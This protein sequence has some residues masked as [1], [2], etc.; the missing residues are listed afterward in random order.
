V[1]GDGEGRHDGSASA[2]AGDAGFDVGPGDDAPLDG[3]DNDAAIDAPPD[4]AHD[5]A[6]DVHDAAMYAPIGANGGTVDRLHF[7]VFGDIRP[8]LPDDLSPYPTGIVMQVMDG[9]THENAQF[10]IG[11]G[12]YMLE[13]FCSFCATNQINSLIMGESHFRHHIFH[14]MGNHEC[15][16]INEG[17]CPEENETVALRTYRSRLIPTYA[18]T[19]FAWTIRT[20]LGDA[21]FIATSP[22]AW[23]TDQ[24]T[25]L[26]NELAVQWRYVFVIAHEP[27]T[28]V[29]PGTS[30]I[31][32]QIAA[33]PG[34]VTMRLYG[35]RHRYEHVLPNA[36][37]TGNAGAPLDGVTNWYGFVLIDQRADGNLTVTSYEVG[38]PPTVFESFV[39]T[40]GGTITH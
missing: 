26:G 24:L 3:A 33:R 36:T 38:N 29:G 39:L 23:S 40:P 19:Y 20:S 9:I 14:A 15:L 22:N 16:T 1:P 30:D 11:T 4:V 34:G 32:N 6:H 37:I 2:E 35:H 17:N 27:P 10:A 18:H 25:W 8:S 13:N 28:S 31:E 5:A 21:R 7:A 12:D